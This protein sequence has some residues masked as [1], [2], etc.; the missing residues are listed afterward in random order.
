[1][2]FPATKIFIIGILLFSTSVFSQ[3]EGLFK[4]GLVYQ[5]EDN[6]LKMKFGLRI[7]SLFSTNFRDFEVLDDPALISSEFGIRRGRLKFDGFVGNPKWEYKVELA[8]GNRNLGDISEFNNMG[9]R[10][11]LDAVVKYHFTKKYSLWVGQTKLPGNRERVV[12]SQK[13]QFVDRNIANSRFN[14]D[15]DQGIQFRAKESFGKTKFNWALAISMGEGRNITAENQGGFE[16]TAR[17]EWLPFGAFSGKGDYVE[18]DIEHEKTPKLSIGASYDY[19]VGAARVRSNQGNWLY[20]SLGNVAEADLSTFIADFM[21]KY[22]GWSA[23]GEYFY[24]NTENPLVLD[25][26][27]SVLGAYYIGQGLSTQ[28]GYLFRSNWE[29]A[30]RFSYVTPDVQSDSRGNY[31]QYTLGV[32]KYIYGH[33][34]KVQSDVSYMHYDNVAEADP[35][36]FRLQLEVGF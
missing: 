11:V 8:L 19:N 16:Y 12:S 17:A 25:W 23:T 5:N 36:M 20:D 18:S 14:L 22:N 30:G 4:K 3:E 32:S 7:Q 29:L 26:N 35:L 10:L 21:F 33:T 6:T 24:R 2:N 1:M 27:G 9:A 15:R 28:V 31:Q 34:V 13:L